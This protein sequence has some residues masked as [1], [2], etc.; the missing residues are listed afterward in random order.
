M[1]VVSD[2]GPLIAL[3][4]INA[5]DLLSDLYGKVYTSQSVYDETVMSAFCEVSFAHAAT[6]I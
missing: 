4:K 5:L 3:A 6:C 2:A 1:I